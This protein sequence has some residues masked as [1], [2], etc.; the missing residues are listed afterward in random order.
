MRVGSVTEDPPR[1][2]IVNNNGEETN[3]EDGPGRVARKSNEPKRE[4]PSESLVFEEVAQ[5]H[6][7]T[8]SIL[9]IRE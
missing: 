8:H 3:N 1:Y 6:V 9:L 4:G 2:V 5:V 7:V